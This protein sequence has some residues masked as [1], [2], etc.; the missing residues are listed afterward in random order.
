M[1]KPG[2]QEMKLFVLMWSGEKFVSINDN[3]DITEKQKYGKYVECT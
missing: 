1:P 3:L 2:E